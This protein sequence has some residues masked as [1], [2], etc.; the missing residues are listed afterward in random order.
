MSARC[1]VTLVI[2]Q[3]VRRCA[4]A[5]SVILAGTGAEMTTKSMMF[6]NALIARP[7]TLTD[8]RI[9]I[10]ALLLASLAYSKSNPKFAAIVRLHANHVS[11]AVKNAPVVLQIALYLIFTKR[12]A[13]INVH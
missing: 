3:M 8:L 1:S 11:T 2:L 5:K 9:R 4:N 13:L 6:L 7:S 10:S 12:H